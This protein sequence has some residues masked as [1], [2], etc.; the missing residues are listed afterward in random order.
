MIRRILTTSTVALVALLA[1]SQEAAAQQAVPVLGSAHWGVRGGIGAEPDQGVFGVHLESAPL[2]TGL[3]FK[4]NVEVG[5]GDDDDSLD[6]NME[7]AYHMPF[8]KTDWAVY[9]GG[10]PAA[11]FAF[12][13][14]P[15]L[16]SGIALM[17][18]LEKGKK[19]MFEVKVGD[20][21]SSRLKLTAGYN[22]K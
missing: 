2:L 11:I 14:E 9:I 16:R 1:F 19:W 6:V 7:F 21:S 5:I 15:N 22:F 10:G 12:E 3:T 8:Q 17:V 20:G 13:T 4:P 18:G